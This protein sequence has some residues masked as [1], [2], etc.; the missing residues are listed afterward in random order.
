MLITNIEP[1]KRSPRR[2]NIYLDDEFAFG[3]QADVLA[4]FGL[5]EG[6]ELDKEAVGRVL[7]VEERTLAKNQA[8]RYLGTRRRT[9]KEIRDKLLEKEFTPATIESVLADLIARGLV[10]DAEFVKAFVHDA[11]M[12]KPAGKRLLQ[13][14]LRSKGIS[15]ALLKTLLNDEM[16]PE[17]EE[18]LALKEAEKIIG[19]YNTS[20]KSVD[21]PRQQQRLIQHLARRGFSWSAISPV[22]KKL[23]GQY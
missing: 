19:K 4:K 1:Q 16:S 13:M 3:I 14:K 10:N 7:L 12:R 2:V 15:P 20:R 22:V 9:E 17:Q 21:P 6:D 18:A 23:F 8:L 11:Q 5:R